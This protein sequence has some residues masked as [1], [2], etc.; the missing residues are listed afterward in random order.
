VRQE[1]NTLLLVGIGAGEDGHSLLGA[2]VIGQVRHA[3]GDVKILARRDG[4]VL[5]ELR[6]VEHACFAADD[7][8]RRLVLF[9]QMRA[10]PPARRNA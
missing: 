6:A 7:I 3:G 5:F 10:R 4:E 1:G 2:V 9:V 8:D